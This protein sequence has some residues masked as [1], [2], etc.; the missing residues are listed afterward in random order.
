MKG[1]HPVLETLL[2][3]LILIV[4][5][6]ALFGTCAAYHERVYGSWTC[7]LRRCVE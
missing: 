6:G 2:T 7:V 3:I 5:A 1:S 4:L